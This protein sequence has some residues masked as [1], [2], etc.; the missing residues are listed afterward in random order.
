MKFTDKQLDSFI[1]LYEQEYGE[2]IDR[3]KAL[4]QATSLVSLVKSIYRPMT[5]AEWKK[6]TAHIENISDYC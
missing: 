5:K 4:E 6:Y 3:A 1:A 2:K